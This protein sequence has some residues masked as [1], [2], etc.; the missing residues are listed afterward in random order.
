MQSVGDV[1]RTVDQ[2]IQLG[3]QHI[4]D[5]AE[6]VFT[7]ERNAEIALLASTLALWAV[8]LFYLYSALQN[9]TI[10]DMSPYVSS[11]NGQLGIP[12]Y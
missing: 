10:A 4:R 9:Y 11:L 6:R 8:L 7:R 12:G 3:W 5:W 2:E 1:F